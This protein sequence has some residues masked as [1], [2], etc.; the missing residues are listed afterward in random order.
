L[1]IVLKNQSKDG[2][3]IKANKVISGKKIKSE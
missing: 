2:K 1:P 3:K